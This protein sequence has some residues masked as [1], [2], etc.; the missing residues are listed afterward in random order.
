MDL[1]LNGS[2][3]QFLLLPK[4]FPPP[5]SADAE[6]VVCVGGDL[7]VELL[8]D[9]YRHGIFPWPFDADEPLVWFSL[10]PRGI[11]DP[12]RYRPSGRVLRR[13]KR[14]EFVGTVD[15]DFA[16]VMA[17]CATSPG[18]LGETWITPAMRQ[19]Y[20]HLHELGIAHSAEVRHDGELVGGV[21]GVAFG[22]LFAAESMFHRRRD[23]SN[24]ALTLLVAHLVARGYRLID[25]QQL[26]PHTERLGA[27]AIPRTEY[28]R[29]L[30]SVRDLDVTFGTQLE[31]DPFA[32][33]VG[34]NRPS[35]TV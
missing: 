6:G 26:T 24:A 9:A 11:I 18:R 7:S 32:L 33:W 8:V 13:L 20:E 4:Y 30:V 25:I 29:R 28:L 35:G 34:P 27:I 15:T 17:G 3:S 10:D 22:G 21:Y 1:K 19:A 5:Q 31:G 16:G 23:G 2:M 14:G 12:S